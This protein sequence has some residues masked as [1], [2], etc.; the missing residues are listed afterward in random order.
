MPG[1]G[2]PEAQFFHVA[3]KSQDAIVSHTR[4]VTQ[5]EHEGSLDEEE[6]EGSQTVAA[7]QADDAEGHDQMQPQP[8]TRAREEDWNFTMTKL[9]Q[10]PF[11]RAGTR[12]QDQSAYREHT[13]LWNATF[14]SR[15]A[16]ERV[17]QRNEAGSNNG[18]VV[19]AQ[20]L[21]DYGTT[22]SYIT[23]RPETD[24]ICIK[25]DELDNM[26]S[27]RN[28]GLGTVPTHHGFD[29][30]L[31]SATPMV[32]P[33]GLPMTRPWLLRLMTQWSWAMARLINDDDELRDLIQLW[34]M[35]PRLKA[36]EGFNRKEAVE[37][38]R[39]IFRARNRIYVEVLHADLDDVWK[40]GPNDFA[41]GMTPFDMAFDIRQGMMRWSRRV[42]TG[43]PSGTR[44]SIGVLGC[45]MDE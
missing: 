8:V 44:P 12:I 31:S 19:N 11:Y 27:L 2:P 23:F 29:F 28:L 10:R 14:E 45:M 9:R 24:L 1:C 41:L 7:T 33:F 3:R 34:V 37:M 13:G 18:I 43:N 5:P 16:C 25:P 17:R 42:G 20:L 26:A 38:G 32:L 39:Q 40:V 6:G 21:Y 35:D 30:T 22:G 4:T 15:E 36:K